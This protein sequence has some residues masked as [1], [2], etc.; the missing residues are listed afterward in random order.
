LGKPQVTPVTG[1]KEVTKTNDAKYFD[2]LEPVLQLINF[3]SH[4]LFNYDETG[5]TVVQH[6]AYKVMFL[7]GKRRM[8]LSSA[9]MDSF[10]TIVTCMNATITY[11]PLRLVIPKSNMKS[12][13]LDDVPPGSIAAFHKAGWIQ[14]ESFTRR[15]QTFCPF[16][17]DVYKR[18]RYFDVVWLLFSFEE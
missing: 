3:S 12:E 8:S 16:C 2:I 17:A 10:V 4:R 6:K 9:E 7:K 15:V 5:V 14:K 13:L 11:V 18:S 1:V